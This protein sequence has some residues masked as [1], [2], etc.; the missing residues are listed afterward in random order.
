M[1]PLHATL[2]LA[3]ATTLTAQDP[4]WHDLS[5]HTV[6]MIT[7]D[8][9]VRLEVLDWGGSGRPV[10]LLAGLGSTAH[11]FDDFAPKLAAGFHVYG[12]TRR[13]FGASSAP[14]SG[15]DADRLGDD[16][17]AVVEALKLPAPVI[18]GH[19]IAGEELSSVAARHASRIAGLVYLDA[20][21][22]YAF[23]NGEGWTMEDFQAFMKAAPNPPPPGKDDVA[24]LS[25]LTAWFRRTQGVPFPESEVHEAM[26]HRSPGRIGKAVMDGMKKFTQIKVPVLAICA[27]PQDQSAGLRSFTIPEQRAKIEAV[28]VE[29]D[30][31]VEKQIAAI[32]QGVPGARVVVLPRAHHYVF[33][34]NEADVLREMKSFIEKLP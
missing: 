30:A 33:L 32:R 10:A 7:V 19:S 28:L 11:V 18:A 1:K 34:S 4:T 27:H 17:V 9:D 8:G 22:P 16:V 13:G 23:D 6:Q 25:A 14:A 21:Y 26:I 12:I 2:L 3:L 20:A 24:S 15:Y 31:Q 29:A 5:P